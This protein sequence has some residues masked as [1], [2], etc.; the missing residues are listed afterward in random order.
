MQFSSTIAE[1]IISQSNVC[2][3]ES[4][5]SR[6]VII[7]YA[8]IY[9][10]FFMAVSIYSFKTLNDDP[11]FSRKSYFKQFKRW[12]FDLKKRKSCYIPIIAHLFDQMTDISV[13]IQFY[14]IATDETKSANDWAACNGLNIWYLFNL[15]IISLVVYRL[16]TGYL[17]Y[18]YTNKS[19]TRLISQ[20]LD[21]ELFRALYINYLC[22]K[23]EPC[24]PQRWITAMEAALES[25]P[26]SLIQLI[27]LVRTGAFDVT[28]VLIII[29][30]TSS[31]WSI[32]SKLIADDKAMVYQTAK[33]LDF[34]F[35]FHSAID[36][37]IGS[38]TIIIVLP[39]AVC[40]C[41]CIFVFQCIAQ[42]FDYDSEEYKIYDNLEIRSKTDGDEPDIK[43][44]IEMK[45]GKKINN[46]KIV[47][48]MNPETG[49]RY[50]IDLN[51]KNGKK[52]VIL[53]NEYDRY[54][55]GEKNTTFINAILREQWFCPRSFSWLYI[56]RV[57]WRILDVT[58]RLFIMIL[59]WLVIGGVSLVVIICLECAV[60]LAICVKTQHWELIVNIVASVVSLT[61]VTRW[62]S[63]LLF[64]YRA[65]SNQIIMSLISVWL[66]VEF[67][68]PKCTDYI[69]RQEL[70]Q[71]S[72]NIFGIFVY[73]WI[74]AIL[75]PL[76]FIVL[77]YFEI[78]IDGKTTSRA[79]AQMIETANWEGILEIQLYA[80]QYGIYDEDDG[81]TLLEVAVQQ[82][83]ESIISYLLHKRDKNILPNNLLDVYMKNP[84]LFSPKNTRELISIYPEIMNKKNN[85]Y[86]NILDLYTKDPSHLHCT[87]LQCI[88]EQQPNLVDK[89]G[90]NALTLLEDLVDC[91]AKDA[92]LL[93][94]ADLRFIQTKQPQLLNKI[95]VSAV[96]AVNSKH[97]QEI[98]SEHT[99][100]LTLKSMDILLD[101]YCANNEL[102]NSKYLQLI[103]K[104]KPELLDQVFTTAVAANNKEYIKNMLPSISSFEALSIDKLLK[105]YSKK[106]SVLSTDDL[107][108]IEKQ[109]PEFVNKLV[110]CASYATNVE[111]VQHSISSHIT[112]L[113]VNSLNLLLDHYASNM[114]LLSNTQLFQIQSKQP[115]LL[116]KLFSV[117]NSAGNVE[118]VEQMLLQH[119]DT[120]SIQSLTVS[121]D[122]YAKNADSLND[123]C[124]ECLYQRAQKEPELLYNFF[125][126]CISIN[127][128]QYTNRIISNI[129]LFDISSMYKL[130]DLYLQKRYP[131]FFTKQ[132]LMLI[133]KQLPEIVN[134]LFLRSVAVN[135][136]EYYVEAINKMSEKALLFTDTKGQGLYHYI[137]LRGGDVLTNF[138][139]IHELI[140]TDRNDIDIEYKPA[141]F[142]EH[143]SDFDEN[144]LFY[145]LGTNQASEDMKYQNPAQTGIVQIEDKS[146]TNN[147]NRANVVNNVLERDS[148]FYWDTGTK[149][150]PPYIMIILPQKFKLSNY[151]L[152]H[153]SFSSVAPLRNW[154]LQVSADGA[155]WIP[156]SQHQNDTSLPEAGGTHTW[157]VKSNAYYTYFRLIMTSPEWGGNL[158]TC[159]GM[160]FYGHGV[161]S[162][163]HVLFYKKYPECLAQNGNSVF[164][165]AAVMED[166]KIIQQLIEKYPQLLDTVDGDNRN[167]LDCC[168][169]TQ[170]QNNELLQYI[171]Q[172]R[173]NMLDKNGY[174]ANGEQI[175]TKQ[176]NKKE[177]EKT[178]YNRGESIEENKMELDVVSTANTN[179][180]DDV[181]DEDEILENIYIEEIEEVEE[182]T[183][184][185]SITHTKEYNVSQLTEAINS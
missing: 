172:Q 127:N 27:Y 51:K 9:G 3:S 102:L 146:G 14:E 47:K 45:N 125:V 55:N 24:N 62:I 124:L 19:F 48:V 161:N 109:R 167:I 168:H 128:E 93:S 178:E 91:Y 78:F 141:S 18:I 133:E 174:N 85:N 54:L 110:C 140:N 116:N 180:N 103:Q 118:Y 106:P 26:Q 49:R 74:S 112:V 152:K 39:V 163:N 76:I 13:A 81:K 120:L 96:L 63:M 52:W 59:T 15:T 183:P 7:V 20:I 149:S 121:L 5:I 88:Y 98:L 84:N 50:E 30:L 155:K 123:N 40:C 35:R 92:F 83:R 90:R 107:M 176:G 42:L 22:G 150:D 8:C 34:K 33:H 144:G 148:K 166:W 164:F 6:N 46:G 64:I 1:S 89:N 68:C 165:E 23:T 29:S 173:P 82:Q 104:R 181:I 73:C 53:Y 137:S 44:D 134:H 100:S 87:V 156:I 175:E 154:E 145:Y 99:D 75:S 135:N 117:A 179:G 28:N 147:Q 61:E 119:I 2:I 151:S 158:L 36:L 169:N 132:K 122:C 58:S 66:F 115:D 70:S 10:W 17:I 43:M 12:I 157:E 113:T 56:W 139:D 153:P 86:V 95:F 142:F 105:H 97:V 65:I 114:G 160:E 57:I 72:S 77:C 129:K 143:E 182:H 111:Y 126:S 79:L 170:S 21:V 136:K 32:V 159:S 60:I 71:F 4:I 37:L 162:V 31:L 131:S 108:Q 16:I 11:E 69:D 38:L 171:Y 80:G 138:E 177:V 101:N 25:T 67:E 184:K 130:L 41:P 94:I 185:Q